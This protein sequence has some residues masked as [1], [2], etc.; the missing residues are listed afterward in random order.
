MAAEK[1]VGIAILGAG[2][3]AKEAYL[4]VLLENPTITLHGVYSRSSSSAQSFKDLIPASHPFAN[5]TQVYSDDSSSNAN[6]AAL[7]SDATIDSVIIALPIPLQPEIIKKSLLAGK[8]V[9]SEKPVSYDVASAKELIAWYRTSNAADFH[10]GK[11]PGWIIAENFGFEP[12]FL[13]VAAKLGGIG[14][15]RHVTVSM[16]GFTG[17][18]SKWYKTPWRTV[19]DYQG[20]FLLDGGVHF[21][22]IFRTIFNQAPT[23]VKI[24]KV[25]ALTKL[26]QDWLKPMDTISSLI[27]FSNGVLGNLELS[28][29]TEK[30]IETPMLAIVGSEGTITLSNKDGVYTVD[31]T[32]EKETFKGI[33]VELELKE[34]VAAVSTGD[35]VEVEKKGGPEVVL[36][37]LKVIEACLKSGEKG[38]QAVLLEQL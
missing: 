16:Y 13:S 4:P 24:E 3:F 20:G 33:G 28:F 14:A 11:K 15:I 19:P 6:L 30:S 8:S 22:S 34:F 2:I 38:G 10:G 12:S 17:K 29:G 5:S 37:D 7:L 9:L 35:W 18:D 23:E 21:A 32:G 27:L 26:N 1:K 36:Q 31:T 25:I